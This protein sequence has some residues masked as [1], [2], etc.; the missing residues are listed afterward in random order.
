MSF[1][2]GAIFRIKLKTSCTSFNL[3][4]RCT[5]FNLEARCMSFNLG[6][7]C[8]SFNLGACCTSF[9]FGAIFRVKK[10]ELHVILF[11]S[12]LHVIQFWRHLSGKKRVARHLIWGELHVIQVLRHL[13]GE[14]KRVARHSV[15]I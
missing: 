3:G 11:G 5:S 13:S 8:T 7:C 2:F 12:V 4:A 6:A 1:K 10:N 15:A 14:Q 9:N